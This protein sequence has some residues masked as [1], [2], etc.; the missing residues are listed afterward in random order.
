MPAPLAFTD[1]I[2]IDTNYFSKEEKVFVEM[3]LFDQVV[4][5]LKRFFKKQCDLLC[6]DIA[7][8]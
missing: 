1:V 7:G 2:G 3:V 8:W 4:S 6:A 5:E